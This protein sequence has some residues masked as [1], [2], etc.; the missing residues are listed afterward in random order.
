MGP[1]RFSCNGTYRYIHFFPFAIRTRDLR[2]V[3]ATSFVVTKSAQIRL[4]D[5]EA[6]I[7]GGATN[8]A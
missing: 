6:V 2:R 7:F 3:K 5:S 8:V 4:C 1:S